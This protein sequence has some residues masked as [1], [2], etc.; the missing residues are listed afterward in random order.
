[1]NKIINKILF[2]VKVIFLLIAFVVTLY[3]MLMK[4]DINGSSML[5]LISLF[6]PLL[7]VLTVFVF[8]LFLNNGNDNMFFNICCVLVLIAIIIIDYR[9]IFDK[10]IVSQYKLNIIYFDGQIMHIKIMLYLIFIGNLMLVFKEK[11]EKK[12][13]MHS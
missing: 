8:S 9:T 11:K 10:N 7:A 12:I 13:K 5:S 1:M 4:N 6:I 3:I 2:Y